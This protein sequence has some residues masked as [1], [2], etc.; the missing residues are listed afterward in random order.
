MQQELQLTLTIIGVL[1]IG[2]V[3]LHGLW[4]TRKKTKKSKKGTFESRNW[5]PDLSH[6]DDLNSDTPVFD[7]IGVGRARVVINPSPTE[8]DIH[9]SLTGETDA[10]LEFGFDEH[11]NALQSTANINA[12]A[13]NDALASSDYSNEQAIET[14][15][16]GFNADDFTFQQDS[17][18]GHNEHE[19][20]ID[21]EDVAQSAHKQSPVYSNVVTQPKPLMNKA[22]SHDH[23]NEEDDFGKP[24]PFLMKK[25]DG[26]KEVSAAPVVKSQHNEADNSKKISASTL[27]NNNV[28]KSASKP[29]FSLN[30]QEGPVVKPEAVESSPLGV[31]KE[32]SFAQQAKR[33]V[34]RNKKTV[35]D[36]IRKPAAEHEKSKDEQMRID[37]EESTS[38]RV[39]PSIETPVTEQSSAKP[40]KPKVREETDVLVLNVRASDENPIQGA[41]LLPMLLTLGF[42]F[43]EHDIF[44]RHV[45]TNGKGPILFSLTNMFKPGVFDIDNIENFNTSGISLFMML[46]IEGDAQQVFNMMHNAARKLADEFGCRILDGNKVGLSTQSLQQYIERIREFERRRIGR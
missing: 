45:T 31:E 43:G 34:Q 28:E 41:A 46:P 32:L 14:T 39:A 44:H 25:L 6:E 2:G 12:S 7:D 3:L 29:D 13:E 17:D 35:A 19:L 8:P 23:S 4:S 21:K 33:F 16:L 15:E 1:I 10:A 20:S 38:T 26:Q 40:N 18:A 5:E 30:I 37:F 36:K 42:K 22:S 27:A 11:E 9:T 24:P